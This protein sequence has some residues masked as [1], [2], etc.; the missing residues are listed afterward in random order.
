MPGQCGVVDSVL[1]G[2]F[3]RQGMFDRDGMFVIGGQYIC[4]DAT[5]DLTFNTARALRVHLDAHAGTSTCFEGYR[6]HFQPCRFSLIFFC[7]VIAV[8]LP[9]FLYDIQ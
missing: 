1:D 8:D 3:G 6:K 4:H 7:L 2:V 5:C 9:L